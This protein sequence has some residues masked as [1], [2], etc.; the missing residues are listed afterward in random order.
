MRTPRAIALYVVALIVVGAALLI[1]D[2]DGFDHTASRISIGAHRQS[3]SLTTGSLDLRATLATSLRATLADPFGRLLA[4]WLLILSVS[5]LMAGVVRGFKMPTVIGEMIAGIILGPSL[6]GLVAPKPF[7][8]IF[9]VDS[10]GVLRT[11]SQVGICLFMFT[12]GLRLDTTRLREKLRSTIAVSH[13]S[14]VVP[15]LLGAGLAYSLFGEM[16]G[17][18]AT[19]TS[20]TLF[21][22]ISIS[23]TA[24]P[25]LARI[26]QER[27]LTHTV[28]GNIAI[29]CAAIEDMTAWS[30]LAFV[31]A[32]AGS[33]GLRGPLLTLLFVT[34][35][36]AAMTL[37]VRRVLPSC[38][39]VDRCSEEGTSSGTL[40]S[41]LCL[42]FASA[43]CT[44]AM[45][46]HALFGAFI[47]GAIMPDAGAFRDQVAAPIE[48]FSST[49]LLPLYFAFTGLRTHIT[50]LSDP[51]SCFV[52]LLIISVAILGKLGAG[53]LAARFSGMGWR[54]SLQLGALMNSRGLME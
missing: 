36:I 35:H 25:V 5:A 47:A 11:I 30:I 15:F 18:K 41:V 26:L 43:L 31:V 22:G 49:A 20:F 14:I 42:M 2:I 24:F 46:I 39:D 29:G 1:A 28:L 19:P 27:N 37:V 16:A 45:G 33:R 53:S 9:T 7:A 54:E 8:H 50:L 3:I 32:I 52:C 21:L 12:V 44:E 38:L 17:D 34:L 23:I 6:L 13:T 4:Q 40:A 51:H 10:L 48:K